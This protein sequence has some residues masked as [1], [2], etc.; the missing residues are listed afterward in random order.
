MKA[1]KVRI[2]LLFVLLSCVGYSQTQKGTFLLSG[3][4]DMNFLFS[5]IETSRDS[6]ATKKTKTN[7]FGGNIGI[8]YFIADN[9][10]VLLSGT[11]SYAY[12]KIE[13]FYFDPGS[14][15]ITTTFGLI[16]QLSYYFPLDGKLRPSLTIAA[17]YLFLRERDSK[18]TNNNNLVYSL[19]GPSYN[20]AAAVSYFITQSIAFELGFQ[21]THNRLKDKLR[22]NEIQKHNI[23]AG[24]FGVTV[25]FPKKTTN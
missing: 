4:T 8:G 5:N 19:K 22:T 25:F 6:T 2:S 1:K 10:S 3:K 17:G 23:V 16:P 24:T 18:V 11:Y 20:G 7:R 12:K 14:E 21:Y 9:L 13:P 15:T